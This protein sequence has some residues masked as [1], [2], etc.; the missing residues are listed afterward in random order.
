MRSCYDNPQHENTYE[1]S[2]VK[3]GEK[4]VDNTSC[5]T[6]VPANNVVQATPETQSHCNPKAYT[7]MLFYSFRG[8]SEQKLKRLHVTPICMKLHLRGGLLFQH[9]ASGT[10]SNAEQSDV[11]T[12]GNALLLLEG[13][14]GQV[15]RGQAHPSS[16][17]WKDVRDVLLLH[18]LESCPIPAAVGQLLCAHT[19]HCAPL[20]M[21]MGWS[22]NV[23]H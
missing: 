12:V 22:M 4:N 23:A 15:L 6:Q 7:H 9:P 17:K 5:W 18:G 14:Q 13:E 3:E 10:F 2:E 20:L 11:V 1:L 16:S 19:F 21:L 8:I